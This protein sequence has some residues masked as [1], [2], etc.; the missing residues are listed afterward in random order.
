MARCTSPRCIEEL[1][2]AAFDACTYTG[3]RR[4]EGAARAIARS[5]P[6]TGVEGRVAR[7]GQGR[8]RGPGQICICQMSL[9]L[10]KAPD[11]LLARSVAG[12]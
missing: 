9:E 12:D 8:G 10:A 3:V 2:P 5:T 7:R 1:L 4:A 6:G 11:D